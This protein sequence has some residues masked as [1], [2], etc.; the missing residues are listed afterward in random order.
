ML[1]NAVGLTIES[2]TQS[3]KAVCIP[4]SVASFNICD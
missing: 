2:L 4:N 3:I 1:A